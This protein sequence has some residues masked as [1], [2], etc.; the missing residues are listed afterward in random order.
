MMILDSFIVDKRM[1]E[2]LGYEIQRVVR[3]AEDEI[4]KT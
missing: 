4:D 3:F 2:D 1:A